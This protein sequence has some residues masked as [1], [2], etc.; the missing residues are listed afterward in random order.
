MEGG[1]G[2]VV[3]VVGLWDVVVV[4]GWKDTFQSGIID[5]FINEGLINSYRTCEIWTSTIRYLIFRLI[6]LRR[7]EYMTR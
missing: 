6:L 3:V 5:G 7:E 4:V 1:G 2:V